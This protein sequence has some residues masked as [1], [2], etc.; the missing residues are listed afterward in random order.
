[1]NNTLATLVA[2]NDENYNLASIGLL[3]LHLDSCS[4]YSLSITEKEMIRIYFLSNK[5]EYTQ[6]KNYP[7]HI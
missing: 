4:A 6:K 3:S 7:F 1:M 5:D 2:D